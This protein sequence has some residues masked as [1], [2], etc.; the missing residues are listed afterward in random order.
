M[1]WIL[2]APGFTDV[3]AAWQ[4]LYAEYRSM[5]QQIV[6]VTYQ[7]RPL[8]SGNGGEVSEETTQAIFD[9]LTWAYPR[10]EAMIIEAG[11]IPR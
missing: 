9:F 5:L 10:S 3:P 7:I 6:N 1:L 2:D 11:Q 4:P 8:C